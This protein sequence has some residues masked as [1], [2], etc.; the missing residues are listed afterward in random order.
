MHIEFAEEFSWQ[1]PRIASEGPIFRYC[2]DARI[3]A[4]QREV[5]PWS[6][7]KQ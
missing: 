1:V 7:I 6:T 3:E 4:L 2:S 5:T